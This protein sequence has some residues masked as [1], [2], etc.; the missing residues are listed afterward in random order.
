MKSFT[1][2][3]DGASKTIPLG[4]PE[5]YFVTVAMTTQA[6][7]EIGVTISDN[8][9]TYFCKKRQSMEVLP[10]ITETF[11]VKSDSAKMTIDVPNSTRLDARM[12]IMDIKNE[13]E[14]L[15]SRTIAMVAED[16]ND[17]DYNDLQIT[18]SAWRSRG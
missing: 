9:D 7:F 8:N 14:V 1:I 3:A 2:C 6:A 10:I 13:Q 17:Y 11:F 5:N 4:I 18:I 15:I 16:S 12:E